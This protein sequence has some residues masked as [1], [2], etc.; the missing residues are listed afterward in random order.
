MRPAALSLF[1]LAFTVAAFALDEI[2]SNTAEPSNRKALLRELVGQ[3]HGEIT[4]IEPSS[5]ENGSVVIGYTSGT[6]LFCHGNRGCRKFSGTPNASVE[7][8]AV[9]RNGA[10]E[11]IWVTY[12]QGALYQCAKTLC[13]K[14]IWSE[15]LQD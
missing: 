14:F 15:S 3:D 13:K 8:I 9:S 12:A 11:V 6:V 1:L 4:A 10:S 5:K 7:Q 2:A